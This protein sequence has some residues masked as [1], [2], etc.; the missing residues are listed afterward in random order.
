M[1][2][3]DFRFQIQVPA[4]AALPVTGLEDAP[5]PAAQGRAVEPRRCPIGLA[6][7]TWVWGGWGA[8]LAVPMLSVTKTICD[9]VEGFRGV[10]ELLGE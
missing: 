9:R 6:F 8:L 5:G 1:K 3:E 7:W 2:I 10:G 4:G